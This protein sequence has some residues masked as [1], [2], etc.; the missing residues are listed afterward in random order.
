M[1]I[2]PIV[3]Q[4]D[5]TKSGRVSTK[6]CVIQNTS[7]PDHRPIGR[8]PQVSLLRLW[9]P[10]TP[11]SPAPRRTT[12]HALWQCRESPGAPGFVFET[13]ESTNSTLQ[14][15]TPSTLDLTIPIKRLRSHV[16]HIETVT[17]FRFPEYK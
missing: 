14:C 17:S 2:H 8:V 12:A 13:W 9:D 15:S 1:W 6:V 11:E 10:I 3:A 16:R 4:I 5:S 7:S